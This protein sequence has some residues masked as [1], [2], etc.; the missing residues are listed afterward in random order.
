M[1]VVV[2]EASSLPLIVFFTVSVTVVV[3]DTTT[4]CEFLGESVDTSPDVSDVTALVLRRGRLTLVPCDEVCDDG[5]STTSSSSS[6]KLI[7]GIFFDAFFPESPFSKPGV[8]ER[9]LLRVSMPSASAIVLTIHTTES[10]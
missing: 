6:I 7:V 3:D 2:D 10:K 5:T 8:F 1:T 4:F 9:D